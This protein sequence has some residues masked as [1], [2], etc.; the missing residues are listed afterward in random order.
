MSTIKDSE[1]RNITNPHLYGE[2]Y[3]GNIPYKEDQENHSADDVVLMAEEV[4]SQYFSGVMDN[5]EVFFWHY[6]RFRY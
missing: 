2:E 6:A 3:K 4:G 5:A 1:G